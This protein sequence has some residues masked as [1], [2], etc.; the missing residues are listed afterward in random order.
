MK[1][2]STRC[3]L[4]NPL[5]EL[6]EKLNLLVFR[7]KTC[8][9]PVNTVEP[10]TTRTTRT[11]SVFFGMIGLTL[12]RVTLFGV[13]SPRGFLLL[14]D[15]NTLWG[16]EMGVMLVCVCTHLHPQVGQRCHL[17][18]QN[19]SSM[20]S[21]LHLTGTLLAKLFVSNVRPEC[22]IQG[23]PHLHQSSFFSFFTAEVEEFLQQSF[24]PPAVRSLCTLLRR[25][26]INLSPKINSLR[27]TIQSTTHNHR[28][29][30]T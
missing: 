20:L 27:R 29:I 21:C 8:F 16:E 3:F 28:A 7:G 15:L 1:S 9:L 24:L 17:C 25:C 22:F 12:T 30:R 26:L 2:N 10:Q 4:N 11:R 6:P 23:Q 18:P 19:N 14:R 13:S 5:P